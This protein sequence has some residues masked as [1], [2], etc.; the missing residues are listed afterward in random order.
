M[1]GVKA[2][3]GTLDRLRLGIVGGTEQFDQGS[4]TPMWEF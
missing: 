4:V 1:G 2:I 3:S